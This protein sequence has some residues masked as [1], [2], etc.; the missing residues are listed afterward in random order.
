MRL[1]IPILFSLPLASA[2]SGVIRDA[3]AVN[4]QVFDYVIVGGG[5]GGFAVAGRL[6][7]DPGV[8]VLVIEAGGDT[9]QDP[10]VSDSTQYPNVYGRDDLWWKWRTTDGKEMMGGKML[11]GSTGING[12]TYTRGQKE[13]YDAL[14][15][16]L[17]GD[18]NGGRW[19][20]DGMF[21][22]MKK[23]E[24]FSP[25]NDEQRAKG[26]NYNPDYHGYS[27][28]VQVTF[29][30]KMYGQQMKAFHDVCATNFSIPHSDDP[31]GGSAAVVGFVPNV[32][33]HQLV[34]KTDCRQSTG[35]SG[36]AARPP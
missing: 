29:P 4:N 34:Q 21:A 5:L 6:S 9:R 30:S 20:W 11:G 15:Q 16:L 7:E 27:G 36:T 32:S 33:D 1:L 23:A 2:L 18:S 8:T 22:A 26:A 3:N 25:P 17:G 31:A 12:M 10:V 13:Q 35:G 28:P 24:S 14:A 19:T